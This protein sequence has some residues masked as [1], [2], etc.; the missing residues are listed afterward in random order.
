[1]PKD[2]TR[3]NVNRALRQRAKAFG[4]SRDVAIVL[5]LILIFCMTLGYLGLPINLVTAIFTTLF[6]ST[7]FTL[8]DGMG[9][10]LA[11]LRKPKYYTRGCLYYRSPLTSRK[12]ND[13]GKKGNKR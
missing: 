8:K 10:V 4:I 13:R 3:I 12:T 7:L 6:L 11:K 2:E 5:A 1:M 9:E